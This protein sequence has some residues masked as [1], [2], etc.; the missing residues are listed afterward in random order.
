VQASPHKQPAIPPD[1]RTTAQRPDTGPVAASP[2]IQRPKVKADIDSGRLLSWR[3]ET[4][5]LAVPRSS[6]SLVHHTIHAAHHDPVTGLESCHFDLM[7]MS[8]AL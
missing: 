6:Q 8:T 3:N 2:S 4:S 7:A 1:K 5:S